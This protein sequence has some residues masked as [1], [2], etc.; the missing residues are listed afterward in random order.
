[1]TFASGCHALVAAN[2][3]LLPTT[4]IGDV[5]MLKVRPLSTHFGMAGCSGCHAHAAA[6]PR[7]LPTTAIGDVSMLKPLD[8]P[9]TSTWP[10]G[11]TAPLRPSRPITARVAMAPGAQTHYVEAP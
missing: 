6:N 8:W 11:P 10:P 5:S 4:A 2:T 7:L 1:M 9:R 3:R